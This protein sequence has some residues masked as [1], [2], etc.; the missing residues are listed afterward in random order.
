M[1][2]FNKISSFIVAGVVTVGFTAAHA[3]TAAPENPAMQIYREV[4]K[5]INDLVHT[6]LDVRFDYKK[7]Y[8][9]GKEWVTL[10]PHFYPTD[11]LRL[12]AKGMDLKNISVVKNGKNIPLKFTYQDSSSVAIQLD[13]VYRNNESYTIYI[14]YTAKPNELKSHGSAAITDDKGLYFINPDGTEK[15]KPTQIWTQGETES[16]S[17]WF[18][19]IDKP[20]QKT[21]EE[22][23]MT[24]PAKYVT[25]SNGRLASQKTN[26]DGT[27][28]DTWKQELPHSPY[29]FMMAVG[30]FKIY[31]DKWRN[32]EVSYYLEPKY[33]PYA[34][35]IFG[36]TP[37]VIEFYSKTLGVDYPWYKYS[38]IV[39]RDYVS[40]A[41]ENTSATLHGEYVQATPRELI[42]AYYNNGRSTIVH[43]LFHQWFGDYV[44]AES[45]SNLTVNESFANF[46]ET[47]WAEHKY[48]KDAGDD[49][50]YGDM[51]SYL[52]SPGANTKNLVRFNYADKE[53][54]FDVV[55]YQKGGRI[56]NMLR[57]YLGDAA[58]YKGLNIY[59]KTNAFKNGEAQQLRLAFEEAS[60][61]D[62]N[63]YFN[64]WYYGAGHPILDISYKWDDATKTE[65]VYLQQNQDGQTFK[66]PMAVDIYAGGTKT[67]HKVWMNNKTDSL[68]FKLTTRP[69]LV[70]VDADKILL[71]KKN[72]KKTLDE[73]VF[74]YFNAPQYLDRFEAIDAAADKQTEKGAQ[75]VLIAALKD[76]YYGLRIKTIKALNMTNDDVRNAAQPIL[77][78]L[79]QTDDN[80]LVRAAAITTLGKLK[81][82]GNMNLFKQALNSQ[83]Y[84]VQAAALTAINLLDPAQAVQLGKGLEKDNTGVLTT[85]LI[86]VYAGSGTSAQWP[87]VLQHFHDASVQSKFNNL[88]K[89]AEMTGR[90]DKP[91]YTQQGIAE[92]KDLAVKYKAYGVDKPAI[93]FLGDI[94][95]KRVQLNDGASAKAADEAIQLITD[96]K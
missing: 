89:F 83:S 70:N 74:Q 96:E 26:A 72:D 20:S 34:K 66:L 23:S 17:A 1:I 6:K 28:T 31:K 25:L 94:K 44:T 80:T 22:I 92:I 82:Q 76:K 71:V 11:S 91:A 77:A 36:F 60:G 67:R 32:K 13:K 8:M 9:Y 86:N 90:V 43:E 62:L 75:K 38:Q 50:N 10:K 73:Y 5:K 79:V 12:D 52:R 85:A 30:D 53:E 55:T 3:Q 49:H 41:M 69:D 58:F 88:Q 59:L 84:A 14:D 45:W 54:V 95:A 2:N 29:L 35:E 39:V 64:Q 19:T 61:L 65:T 51:Q 46:S 7:R 37:E 4:P 48:G 16:S 93:K 27:R 24:V 18:P 33:A 63:W 15:D 47:I 68:T 42:D 21:T 78:S 87:F 56:L 57:N 40:G 81:A